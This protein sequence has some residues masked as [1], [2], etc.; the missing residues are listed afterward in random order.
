MSSEYFTKDTGDK[1]TMRRVA[2]PPWFTGFHLL[3]QSVKNACRSHH[4]PDRL[5]DGWKVVLKAIQ[6]NGIRSNKCIFFT[7]W[8]PSEIN[9]LDH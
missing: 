6:E 8:N 3:L 1:Q 4:N 7:D 2:E 9:R 5:E